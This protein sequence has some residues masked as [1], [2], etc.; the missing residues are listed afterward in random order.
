MR[1]S[2][3][4]FF[5]FFSFHSFSQLSYGVRAGLNGNN[6]AASSL[7]NSSELKTELKIGF[8]FGGVVDYQFNDLLAL[9]SGLSLNN[10]G[11]TIDLTFLNA[12]SEDVETNY[13]ATYNYLEVP[14]TI[15]LRLKS[16][17]QFSFGPYVALGIGG[18]EKLKTT[19]KTDSTTTNF[20][21]E[22]TLKPVIGEV[23]TSALG[24][25]ESPYNGFAYGFNFSI[26]Y[27]KGQNSFNFIYSH[28]LSNVLPKSTSRFDKIFNRTLAISYTYRMIK[29]E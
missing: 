12:N 3:L 4:T 24:D 5:L 18:R 16:G 27:I 29:T 23:K 9:Q 15:A 11:Y 28:G 19:V 22:S 26:G 20:A 6:V 13:R 21:V 7:V 14:L 1:L 2:F 17:I 25:L 8:H 10:K